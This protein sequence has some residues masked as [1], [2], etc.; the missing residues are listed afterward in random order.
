VYRF[1]LESHL[2]GQLIAAYFSLAR[3][4]LYQRRQAVKQVIHAH[5]SEIKT[6]KLIPANPLARDQRYFLDIE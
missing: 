2:F 5:N 1:R 6:Y 4:V 3:D